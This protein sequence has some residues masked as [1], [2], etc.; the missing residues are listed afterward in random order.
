MRHTLQQSSV[1]EHINHTL[2][3]KVWCM[4]SNASLDKKFWAESMSYASHLINGLSSVAIRGKIPMEIWSEKYAQDYDSIRVFGCPVYYHVKNDN[5]DHC[6]RKSIFVGFKCEIKGF[7]FWDLKD[8][9]FVYSRFVTFDETSTF[10][11]SSSQQLENKTNETLQLVEFDATLYVPV[12]STSENSSTLEETPRVEKK[13][14]SDDV[15][16]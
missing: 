9:K 1:V 5:L 8:K 16:Q 14:V 13:V 11:A 2:L 6:V 7:K 12:S 3:E 10:T 4:L 15:P